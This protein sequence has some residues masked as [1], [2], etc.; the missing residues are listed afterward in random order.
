MDSNTISISVI[1]LLIMANIGFFFVHSH[2][3]WDTDL[4]HSLCRMPN[5]DLTQFGLVLSGSSIEGNVAI[6]HE[7]V[8]WGIQFSDNPMTEEKQRVSRQ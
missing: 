5:V 2:D 8:I 7:V 4:G 3:A 1:Q 6:H